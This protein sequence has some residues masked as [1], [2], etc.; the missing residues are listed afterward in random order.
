M[1]K[2]LFPRTDYCC[3]CGRPLAFRR[4]WNP[5]E[6]KVRCHSCRENWSEAVGCL[7][8]SMLP[9]LGTRGVDPSM[10]FPCCDCG[11]VTTGEA[12]L[13]GAYVHVVLRCAHDLANS[14]WRCEC[15]QE[16]LEDRER[17]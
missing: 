4:L 16:D 17:N 12:V 10:Q 5:L 15:C 2:T 11:D 1:R 6:W 14:L 8:E 7:E 13:Q 3:E 9:I